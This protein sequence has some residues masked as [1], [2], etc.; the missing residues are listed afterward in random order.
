[1]KPNTDSFELI[2][3]GARDNWL[4]A[5]AA[6]DIG[7]CI[8]LSKIPLEELEALHTMIETEFRERRKLQPADYYKQKVAELITDL[9]EN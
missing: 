8:P 1:M 3:E 4:A 7:S 6:N 5:R 2:A 9:T